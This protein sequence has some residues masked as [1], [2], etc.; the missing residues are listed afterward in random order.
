MV[1]MSLNG[2]VSGEF[3][4]LGHLIGMEI[5]IVIPVHHHIV[6]ILIQNGLI[7]L[8]LIKMAG[9]FTAQVVLKLRISWGVF[10]RVAAG[11]GRVSV[12]VDMRRSQFDLVQQLN[13][14]L[15]INWGV[16]VRVAAGAG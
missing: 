16:V 15:S 5:F 14:I 7:S 11:A 12:F 1:E 6:M 8:F 3:H 10:V 13:L 2:L 4:M 9:I